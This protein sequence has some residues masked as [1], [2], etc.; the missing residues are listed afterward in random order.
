MVTMIL[1]TRQGLIEQPSVVSYKVVTSTYRHGA[2][3]L[4]KQTDRESFADS[5][6]STVQL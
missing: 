2:I 4:A 6:Q 5:P 3:E 1:S